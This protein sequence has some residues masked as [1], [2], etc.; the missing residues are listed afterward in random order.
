M[1]TDQKL[2]KAVEQ[3]DALIKQFD[4]CSN[5]WC[6]ITGPATGQHTNGGCKCDRSL[7]PHQI[8]GLLYVGRRLRD[9]VENA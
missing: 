2:A 7:T 9:A 4:G 1:A 8:R 6:V 5:G 3:Y